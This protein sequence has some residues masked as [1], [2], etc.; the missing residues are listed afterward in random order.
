MKT[1]RNG[2]V[3]YGNGHTD[4]INK[5]LGTTFKGTQRCGIDLADFQ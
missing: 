2:N 4:L 1:F 3:F 5:T